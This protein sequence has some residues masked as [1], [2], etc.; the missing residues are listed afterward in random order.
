MARW[1]IIDDTDPRLVYTGN[2]NLLTTPTNQNSPEY[3]G[4]VHATNDPTASVSFNFNGKSCQSF[5]P[6]PA[7][8][9]KVL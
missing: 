9:V 2:W 6:Y 4:T 7:K 8:V 5:I 3:N 1:T